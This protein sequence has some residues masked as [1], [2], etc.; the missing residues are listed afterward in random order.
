MK[1]VTTAHELE[2][3]RSLPQALV[4]IYVNWAN[5]ARNSDVVV[6]D[7]VATWTLTEPECSLPVY[8]VDLSDQKGEIWATIREWL[9]GEGQPFDQLTYG[10]N[11]ALLWVRSGAV[12][13]SVPYVA[14][15]E[16]TKLVAVTKNIFERRGEPGAAGD[17]GGI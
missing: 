6:R 16:R 1:P 3:V 11:G 13:A 12:V 2:E 17:R 4:F 9:K 7:F 5:Q 8:R 15:G 14:A 10:G